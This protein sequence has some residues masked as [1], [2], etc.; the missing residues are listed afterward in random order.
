ML[1]NAD[2]ASMRATAEQA[3]PGTAVIQGGTLTSDSGGG[4]TEAF[5]ASGTVSCR[6][7]PITGTE[8]EDGARISAT[9]EYVITLP[10]E[11]T[12]E[13]NDR[14]VVA[15]ITYNVTAVR[16]RSWEVTRRVEVRKVV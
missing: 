6:V 10:A 1:S 13:T 2:L 8:R 15:G 3:L 16:D 12:V 9:S 14:I 11:T 4:W 7:A 5:T